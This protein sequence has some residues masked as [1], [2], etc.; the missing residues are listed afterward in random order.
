MARRALWPRSALTEGP[1]TS[2]QRAGRSAATSAVSAKPSAPDSQAA[3]QEGRHPRA[4]GLAPCCG[5]A[6]PCPASP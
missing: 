3:D 2:V 6:G 5:D 1:R 4:G